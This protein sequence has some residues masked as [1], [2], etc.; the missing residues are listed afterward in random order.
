MKSPEG[1]KLIESQYRIVSEKDD[2]IASFAY[3]DHKTSLANAKLAT[4]SPELLKSLESMVDVFERFAEEA[5]Y[6]S[7]LFMVKQLIK[8]AKGEDQP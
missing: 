4:L 8:K 7:G 1:W 6:K 5:Q 3:G 2:T